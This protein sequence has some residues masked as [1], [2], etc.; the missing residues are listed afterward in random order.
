M[1]SLLNHL[2]LLE[3]ALARLKSVSM[4]ALSAL[5]LLE[6]RKGQAFIARLMIFNFFWHLPDMLRY[7]ILTIQ[8]CLQTLEIFLCIMGHKKSIFMM[9]LLLLMWI[10]VSNWMTP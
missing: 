1:K 7:M 2:I 5:L 10:N 6:I 3:S 8:M 9:R 4:G